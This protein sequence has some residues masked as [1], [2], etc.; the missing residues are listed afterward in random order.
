MNFACRLIVSRSCFGNGGQQMESPAVGMSQATNSTPPSI[1]LAI[2]TALR[3]S[4]SSLAIMTVKAVY[5]RQNTRAKYLDQ[6]QILNSTLSMTACV[7]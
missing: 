3:E 1:R 5:H 2:K 6:G 4:L 7:S